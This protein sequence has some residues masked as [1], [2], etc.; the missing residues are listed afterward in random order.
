M[1]PKRKI[2]VDAVGGSIEDDLVLE[3][4]QQKMAAAEKLQ[5]LADDYP[6]PPVSDLFPDNLAA[7]QRA[8]LEYDIERADTIGISMAACKRCTSK[9]TCRI[10][11]TGAVGNHRLMKCAACYR[12]K[13]ACTNSTAAIARNT[14]HQRLLRMKEEGT[15][16]YFEFTS[17]LRARTARERMLKQA[18]LEKKADREDALVDRVIL[19][20]LYISCC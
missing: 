11:I 3:E 6:P 12:G 4:L 5:K 15:T 1:P 7:F 20:H 18:R 17:R 8:M 13:C 19:M 14:E 16:E 9:K 10:D 2:P